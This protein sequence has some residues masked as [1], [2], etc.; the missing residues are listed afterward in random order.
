MYTNNYK[1]F[2]FKFL[3]KVIKSFLNIKFMSK[4]FLII[5]TF[6]F[7][8]LMYLHKSPLDNSIKNSVLNLMNDYNQYVNYLRIFLDEL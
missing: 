6:I 2:I 1:S 3:N 4:S 7:D 8:F 5:K